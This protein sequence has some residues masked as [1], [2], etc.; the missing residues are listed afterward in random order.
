[1]QLEDEHPLDRA[2]TL[3]EI[4]G[5]IY[6]EKTQSVPGQQLLRDILDRVIREG[7]VNRQ[8]LEDAATKLAMLGRKDIAK[9]ILA[10]IVKAKMA[11]FD[12]RLHTRWKKDSID[13]RTFVESLKRKHPELDTSQ[14]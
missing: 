5:I 7:L 8:R 10:G 6:R 3:P 12:F 4:F 11:S 1:M 13:G 2:K 14:I 9:V